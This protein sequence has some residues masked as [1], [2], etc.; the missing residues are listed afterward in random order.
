MVHTGDL[1]RPLDNL[2]VIANYHDN[3][4][5]SVRSFIKVEGFTALGPGSRVNQGFLEAGEV[6]PE[7]LMEVEGY[8]FPKRLTSRNLISFNAL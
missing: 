4:L 3:T 5:L 6:K 1:I 7:P 8:V 2:S